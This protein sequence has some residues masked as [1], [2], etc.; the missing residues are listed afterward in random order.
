MLHDVKKFFVFK[1][2]MTTPS[3]VLPLHLKQTFPPV[4]WI[5]TEG[6][7]GIESR[8]PFKIFST[9]TKVPLFS[10]IFYLVV[11]KIENC[12]KNFLDKKSPN[13][14]LWLGK[15]RNQRSPKGPSTLDGD[16][17][18]LYCSKKRSAGNGKNLLPYSTIK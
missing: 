6:D 15:K 17:A 8:L 14:P 13:Q 7:D 12:L 1:S 3:N 16:R 4:I 10:K 2:L 5:F 18:F 9:L 11:P